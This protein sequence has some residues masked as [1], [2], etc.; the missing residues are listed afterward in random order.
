MGDN[1][2]DLKTRVI[3][4]VN[5]Y[6]QTNNQLPSSSQTK[7]NVTGKDSLI[8]M[9]YREYKDSGEY[10]HAIKQIDKEKIKESHFVELPE[11]PIRDF[12]N[13]PE[14]DAGVLILS[15][16]HFPYHDKNWIERCVAYAVGKGIRILHVNG[17]LVDFT[18]IS[19][20]GMIPNYDTD[21]ELSY[22]TEFFKWAKQYFSEIH[23]TLG[24][25]DI[26]LSKKADGQVSTKK[27]MELVAGNNAQVYEHHQAYIGRTWLA[28]H[29]ANYSKVAAK[30]G[31]DLAIKF[32]KNVVYAHTHKVSMGFDASGKF[33]SIESG[34]CFVPEKMAY[35]NIEL[36]NFAIQQRGAVIIHADETYE[37]LHDRVKF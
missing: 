23:Y 31:V 21:R 29:P 24:N 11:S 7:A 3:A 20:H 6:Y 1:T 8:A 19:R 10:K 2:E 28:A 17:D 9:H 33:V 14:I 36:S 5:S 34:G 16:L 4:F 32:H 35:T 22:A 12:D 15:D 37:H 25:H 30:V 13:F 18:N 27:F 26:R